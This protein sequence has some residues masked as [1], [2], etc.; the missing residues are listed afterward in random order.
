MIKYITVPTFSRLSL[1]FCEAAISLEE[2]TSVLT[3]FS[4]GN[5]LRLQAASKSLKHFWDNIF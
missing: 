3:C 1:W 4:G 2:I 5:L